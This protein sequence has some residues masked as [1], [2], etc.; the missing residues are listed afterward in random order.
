M[1]EK[2]EKIK[3]AIRKIV[4]DSNSKGVVVAVSGGV[5]SS[6]VLKLA[7][8]SGIDT[9]ALIMPEKGITSDDDV[10]DAEELIKS[11]GVRYSII[12]INNAFNSIKNSFP[13][14]KFSNK[15]KKIA[16][17]NIKPRIRMIFTYLVANLDNRI[18][19]G[20]GNKS[21]LLLGY[22]TKFGDSAADIEPIGDLYKTE[23]FRLAEYLEIPEK[24]IKKKPSAGLW[25]GQTDEEELGLSYDI[26][27]KILFYLFDKKYSV[28][29]SAIKLNLDKE[30]VE[31]IN[32][33]MEINKHKR[34]GIDIVRL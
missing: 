30:V 28:E 26:I 29:E 7:F 31:K 13:W 8:L 10:R 18:V 33:R 17:I 11:L 34:K 19:L 1:R 9:Y 15:N 12:N 14:D 2:V 25:R 23:V 20:T 4:R 32:L 3:R 27:D 24:I 5:D 21:E 22:V 16:E 6:V